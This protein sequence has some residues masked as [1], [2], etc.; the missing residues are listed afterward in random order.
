MR[1][2]FQKSVLRPLL[3]GFGVGK[4]NIKMPF[5]RKLPLK[6]GNNFN[7]NLIDPFRIGCGE[8]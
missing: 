7:T 4:I 1:G 6:R 2:N 8:K 5:S 3:K